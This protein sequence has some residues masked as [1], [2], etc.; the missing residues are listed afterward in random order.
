MRY[1]IENY[2]LTTNLKAVDVIRTKFFTLS[3]HFQ[4]SNLFCCGRLFTVTPHHVRTARVI[5]SELICINFCKSLILDLPWYCWIKSKPR[6]VHNIAGVK[7]EYL[8][9]SPFQAVILGVMVKL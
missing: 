6:T 1:H 5:H 3:D 9:Y 4:S 2:L 7:K 8:V